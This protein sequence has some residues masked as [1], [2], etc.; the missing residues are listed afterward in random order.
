MDFFNL[1]NHLNEFGIGSLIVSFLT[2]VF[3]LI[4]KIF[5]VPPI[6]SNL[7][8][9]FIDLFVKVKIK[10]LKKVSDIKESQV[11]NHDIFNYLDYMIYSQVPTLN[12]SSEYR[13]VVFRKYLTIYLQKYRY[14]IYNWVQSRKFEDMENSELLSSIFALINDTVQDY[15]KEMENS[16]I[17]SIIIEKMKYKNNDSI[18]VMMDLASDFCT[19][20]FYLTEKNLLKVY[21]CLTVMLSILSKTI[22]SSSYICD[23]I[24]GQLK[25]MSMDGKTEI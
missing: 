22:T 19:S 24:N 21:S 17:P 4:E 18:S 2:L 9:K 11:F 3:W 6:L 10:D 1:L 15:E 14:N 25:G 8:Y 20:P 5:G 13:T 16:G 12:F 23:S 7:F